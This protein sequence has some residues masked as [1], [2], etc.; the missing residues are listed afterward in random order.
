MT[1]YL[2]AAAV[3]STVALLA[4]GRFF[5][6]QNRP[7]TQEAERLLDIFIRCPTERNH[8]LVMDFMEFHDVRLGDLDQDLVQ[9][10]T[11][12]ARRVEA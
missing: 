8:D 1:P 2:I 12:A 9:E 3:L 6:W 4:S 7:V 10:F 5:R 11:D